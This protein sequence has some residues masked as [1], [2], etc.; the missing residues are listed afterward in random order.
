MGKRDGRDRGMMSRSQWK[1]G[2][3]GKERGR[4]NERTR[5]TR[6]THLPHPPPI[7]PQLLGPKTLDSHLSSSVEPPQ[8]PT[9]S[10]PGD[11]IIESWSDVIL[12]ESEDGEIAVEERMF[13]LVLVQRGRWCC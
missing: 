11:V 3:M 7:P 5:E 10:T 4:T 6:I 12:D 9:D 8:S 1:G 13:L 2:R